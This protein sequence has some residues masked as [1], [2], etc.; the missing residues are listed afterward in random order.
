[1]PDAQ[2]THESTLTAL[3]AAL[4]GAN[5]IYGLGMLD[6]GIVFDYSKLMMDVEIARMVKKTVE[7]IIVNDETL[8]LDLIR[9]IGSGGEY[10]SCQHTYDR[11]R[12]VPSQPK[13]INKTKKESWVEQGSKDFTERGYEEAVSILN[14][15]KVKE[16]S[17]EG[18]KK[19]RAIVNEAEKH[20]GV[21]LS[22]Y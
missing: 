19:M 12:T 21:V 11:F 9:Q 4:A 7:G 6:Q 5:I 14:S 17:P 13:L 8:A 1:M 16:I 2:A 18:L 20:Y 22:E 3:I 10:V 15:Y